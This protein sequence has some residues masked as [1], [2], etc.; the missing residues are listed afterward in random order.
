MFSKGAGSGIGRSICEVLARN[1]ARVVAADIN[2]EAVKK[3]IDTLNS[4]LTTKITNFN[5]IVLH[6]L[7]N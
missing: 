7:I 1:G 6:H 3:T 5:N 2:N 4:K